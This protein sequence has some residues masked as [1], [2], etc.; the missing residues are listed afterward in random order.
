MGTAPHR[1]FY[2][3]KRSLPYLDGMFV[4]YNSNIDVIKHLTDKDLRKLTEL[5]DEA[6]IQ[7]ELKLIRGK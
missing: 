5:F 2:N 4:A 7:K 1:R 6:E 3:V